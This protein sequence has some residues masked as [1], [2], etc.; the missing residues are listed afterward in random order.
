[1]S[2]YYPIGNTPPTYV[3][4]NVSDAQA[5]VLL[6]ASG[7]LRSPL[8]SLARDALHRR[9]V[10]FL[11]SDFDRHV[12]ARNALLLWLA[13]H[14]PAAHVFAIWFSIG[15]SA[16]AYASLQRALSALTGPAA[17]EELSAI[18][19]DFWRTQDRACVDR[20]LRDWSGLRLEWSSVQ[21]M[22]WE[23][24]R[25]RWK[26]ESR[27]QMRTAVRNKA[28]CDMLAQTMADPTVPHDAYVD[29]FCAYHETG[30]I[31][32]L[33]EEGLPPPTLV[34][35]TLFRSAAA[36]DLHYGS[37]PFTAFPLYASEHDAHWPF[38]TL[39]FR[40]LKSWVT[41][42]KARKGSVRWTLAVEDCLHLCTTL[43]P[44]QFDVVATSNVADHVGLLPLLM[45][46]RMVTRPEGTLITSTLLHL[47][48]SDHIRGYLKA[49]L[50]LDP[51]LWPAVLGLRCVGREGTL[52]PR[53]SQ[54]ELQMPKFGG[55]IAKRD[56][57]EATNSAAMNKVR[58]EEVLF[59]TLAE[60]SNLPL[61]MNDAVAELV[62]ACRLTRQQLPFGSPFVPMAATADGINRLHLHTL[63]PILCSAENAEQHLK[64]EDHELRDALA[65]WRGELSLVVATLPLPDAALQRSMAPQ[66]HLAVLLQ[67]R[68]HGTLLYSGLWLRYEEGARLV[69]WLVDPLKLAGATARLVGGHPL[70]PPP[71]PRAAR[72]WE[73]RALAHP[74]RL[75]TGCAAARRPVGRGSRAPR[76]G[77]GHAW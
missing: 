48:Y 68:E 12:I 36:Y 71:Y 62:R 61:Q 75:S 55:W 53:S 13:H 70:A 49:N 44:R 23:V 27:D 25:G 45:A 42:L 38:A 50:L 66:P 72:W 1:M 3:L 11:V 30:S 9:P 54:V 17:A 56:R 28:R 37:D 20:V 4:Q 52:G 59:W 18:G 6:L 63:L 47:T 24:L 46:T 16:D 5:N 32:P 22:R 67:T 73:P 14:V 31:T 40:E 64:A 43:V 29:E 51:E 10:A 35:P 57:A 77:M 19:V 33:G 8:Y 74:R 76:Q 39:C 58:S 15:L 60:A 41:E 34:N 7:D 21:A 69:S 26:V 65:F 2:Y